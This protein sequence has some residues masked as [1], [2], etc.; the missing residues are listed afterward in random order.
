MLPY[1]DSSTYTFVYLYL[2][3][4]VSVDACAP[5][6]GSLASDSGFRQEDGRNVQLDLV[7]FAR[8]GS[9]DN[10]Q[11][12]QLA[13][14]Q[15]FLE[16]KLLQSLAEPTIELQLGAMRSW[17]DSL[18]GEPHYTLAVRDSLVA[19]TERL[20]SLSGFDV[21][22][23]L[24]LGDDE[25]EPIYRGWLAEC[26][27]EGR[28]SLARLVRHGWLTTHALFVGPKYVQRYGRD[29]FLKC[30]AWRVTEPREDV[31]CV[32]F[33]NVIP[34]GRLRRVHEVCHIREALAYLQERLPAE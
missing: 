12:L 9:F 27:V 19:L 33:D 8:D 24:H 5:T 26:V 14:G 11:M 15:A 22:F 6:V 32:F 23:S 21:G 2:R 16:C 20:V 18:Y 31:L 13:G 30:P 34:S 29:V 1:P 10:P 17:D 25:D 3:D 28:F 4:D 7:K